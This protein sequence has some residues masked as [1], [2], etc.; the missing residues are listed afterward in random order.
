MGKDSKEHYSS[1]EGAR[2]YHEY[3]K[4]AAFPESSLIK[5]KERIDRFLETARP[6]GLILDAGCG[7]GF[8]HPYFNSR[9]FDL[10]GVD[11]SA[12][13]LSIAKRENSNIEY[14]EMEITNL[15][16]GSDSFDGIWSTGVLVHIPEN[17][18]HDAISEFGRVLRKGGPLF[19]STRVAPMDYHQEECASEGGRIKVHYHSSK[20]ILDLLEKN[21]LVPLWN[22]IE[23]DDSGRPF[24]YIHLLCRKI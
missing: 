7:T 5:G 10:I 11:T 12:E 15:E 8:V 17:K 22:S 3:W 19:I 20:T 16:F 23:P 24:N 4:N 13:M 6:G 9:G 18:L 2:R 1:E 21:H 14:R